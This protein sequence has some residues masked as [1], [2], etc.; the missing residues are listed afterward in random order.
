MQGPRPTN[1]PPRGSSKVEKVRAGV[2]RIGKIEVDTLKHELR[3]P[4][5]INP[6]VTT[7]EFVANSTGGQKAYESAITVDADAIAFNAAVLLLGVDPSHARVPRYHFDTMV[8]GG[9]PLE[10]FVEWS[11]AGGTKR[12]RAE[13]LLYDERT[14]SPLREGPWV[15]TGSSTLNGNFMAEMD[16]VLIGFV[17]SPSPVIENPRPGAIGAYGAVVFNKG[18]GLAAGTKVTLIVKAIQL[19]RSK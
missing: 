8:P 12:V 19:G 15:Y 6:N 7:L 10:L 9:D 13:E 1:L 16:G 11:A 4:G 3:A 5:T 2:Y 18:L 14:K 17:H